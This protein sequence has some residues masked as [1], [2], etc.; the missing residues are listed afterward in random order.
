MLLTTPSSVLVLTTIAEM[1][2][3]NVQ[4]VMTDIG[5]TDT[6]TTVLI[7]VNAPDRLPVAPNMTIVVRPGLRPPG[8]RMIEGLQ[9]TIMTVMPHGEVIM[10]KSLIMNMTAAGTIMNDHLA[11]TTDGAKRG[12][13]ATTRGLLGMEM[14]DGRAKMADGS[15]TYG[16]QNAVVPANWFYFL[17]SLPDSKWSRIP[18]ILALTCIRSESFTC[19]MVFLLVP[20]R[21]E[22]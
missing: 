7:A 13:N 8:G 16:P 3:M 11:A 15:G 19:Y 14:A 5:M 6:G 2:A 21:T 20:T 9:G 18:R 1:I 12:P 10:T 17:P 4:L 22:P